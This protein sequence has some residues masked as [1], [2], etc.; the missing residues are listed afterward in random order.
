[1][2]RVVR[3][4]QGALQRAEQERR[5]ARH[6]AE[7]DIGG[8]LRTE[9]TGILLSTQ[10]ALETP[11]LPAAAEAKL[12]TVFEMADRIRTRLGVAS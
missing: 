3:D 4:V 6:A 8:Q 12:K 9:L 10:Q 11:A 5:L 2:E 7:F 1:M